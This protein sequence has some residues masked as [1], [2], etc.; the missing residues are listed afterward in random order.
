MVPL[1]Q[2]RLDLA[3]RLPDF[4]LVIPDVCHDMHDCSIATG[5]NWLA[6]WLEPLLASRQLKGGVVFVIFDEGR[7]DIGG[8]GRTDA[9]AVGPAVQPGAENSQ[10]LSHYDL[11]ATIE[12]AWHLPRLGKSATATPILGIWRGGN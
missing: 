6:H 7:T 11:L 3:R 4:S 10:A 2:L 9:Y 5:D 1:K 12:A 8:G